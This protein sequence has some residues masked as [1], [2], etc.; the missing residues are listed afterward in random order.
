MF[1]L[2]AGALQAQGLKGLLKNIEQKDSSGTVGK[3]LGKSGQS[4]LST[5]DVAAGLK[6]ALRNGVEKGTQKLSAVDGFF[7]DAAIKVLLPPEA[8]KLER[9]LRDIGLGSEVDKAILSM[10]R[11]AEDAA[12]SAAPI[13]M[14]AIQQMTI[15]DAW[16]ILKGGDT[17]ATAYLKQKTTSPLTEAF[18]PVINNSLEKVDATKYW[19]NMITAYNKIPLTSKIN[20]DLGAYVTEKALSGIFY[21]IALQETQIRK[22]P[23][24]RTTDLLKK[25]FAN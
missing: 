12:K 16:G 25:V 24:A 3:I 11:A 10:N 15:Q 21:Q 4:S 5:N 2:S 6:E 18:R 8:Q 20:P 17:S 23:M 22:D 14:H 1:F 19:N 7:K 9:T 13:F